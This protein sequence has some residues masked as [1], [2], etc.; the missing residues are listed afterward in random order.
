MSCSRFLIGL[1]K[2]CDHMI[3]EVVLS[4]WISN[5]FRSRGDA[6]T[7]LYIL[8]RTGIL[9]LAPKLR[10]RTDDTATTKLATK[11]KRNITCNEDG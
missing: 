2:S 6:T 9:S 8:R 3:A 4:D 7:G 5:S 11:R 1:E 10:Q